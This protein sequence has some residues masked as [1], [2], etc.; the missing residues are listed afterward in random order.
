MQMVVECLSKHA[1]KKIEE[2]LELGWFVVSVTAFGC[3]NIFSIIV[4]EQE[5]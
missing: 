5:K 4:F 2:N 1:K 3:D